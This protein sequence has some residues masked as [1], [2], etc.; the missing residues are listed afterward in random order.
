[1]VLELVIQQ[2]DSHSNIGGNAHV[3]DV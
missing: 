1:V 3:M 2:C